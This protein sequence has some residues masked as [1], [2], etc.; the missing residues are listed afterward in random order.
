VAQVDRN[1]EVIKGSGLK[2]KSFAGDPWAKAILYG[3]A[4]GKLFEENSVL[5][6]K[7][8][9][10][11]AEQ[12]VVMKAFFQV[13]EVSVTSGIRSHQFNL[14]ILGNSTINSQHTGGAGCDFKLGKRKKDGLLY[15]NEQL[16]CGLLYLMKIKAIEPG[17]IGLYGNKKLIGEGEV[18][19][20]SS[21]PH[22]DY[23][24]SKKFSPIVLPAWISGPDGDWAESPG[25]TRKSVINLFK[26]KNQTFLFTKEG[27]SKWNSIE[28]ENS[29]IITEFNKRC[30]PSSKY[31]K[32]ITSGEFKGHIQRISSEVQL[33]SKFE[34]G[35]IPGLFIYRQDFGVSSTLLPYL[36]DCFHLTDVEWGEIANNHTTSKKR[37]KDPK[38][39]VEGDA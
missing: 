10:Q 19:A 7:Q 37:L 1:A 18:K 28:E 21:N 4:K 20:T 39:V 38:E 31:V 8:V 6:Q 5:I 32:K 11:L 23:R 3:N 22:Y 12:L 15:T 35:P 36:P 14:G 24:G 26:K 16:Y 25:A 9:V 29:A 27:A 30:T 33:E 2:W 34:N 13:E 17:G